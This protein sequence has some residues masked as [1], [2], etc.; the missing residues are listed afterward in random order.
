[1]QAARWLA[2]G[3]GVAVLAAVA[4]CAAGRVQASRVL[5]AQALPF[6]AQ[7]LQP[8]Y[9]LLV[10]GDSTAVG[11]GASSPERSLVGQIGSQHPDWEIRN[12]ARNGA[13]FA[14]LPAQL[15]AAGTGY[16]AVL[17]MAGG[18]DVIRMTSGPA[19]RRHIDA[20]LAAAQAHGSRVVLMPSG[21]VGHAPF[22]GPPLSWW[23]SWRSQHLH[24]EVAAAAR[25][26]GARYV[27]LLLPRKQ[28][29][30]VAAPERLHAADGLHPSDEGYAQWLES[31][32]QQGG[33]PLRVARLPGQAPALLVLA[34][35]AQPPARQGARGC[36]GEGCG[37]G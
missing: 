30:F 15:A 17:V 16:D 20:A 21:N 10:V 12:L 7:P 29:P 14:D 11:T 5:A 22:F 9:R 6:Q 26:A 23:M 13:R 32:R 31:L 3:L 33:L 4:G 18:N 8:A 24:A 34:P 35:P 27:R 28:D 25:A 19:L 2:L 37:E 1:M 36:A